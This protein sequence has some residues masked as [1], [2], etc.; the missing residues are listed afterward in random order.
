MG[1]GGGERKDGREEDGENRELKGQ[2]LN[3]YLSLF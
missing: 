3:V 1:R 2:K